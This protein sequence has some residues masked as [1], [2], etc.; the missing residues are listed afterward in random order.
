MNF[1]PKMFYQFMLQKCSIML[2]KCSIMPAYATM[3]FQRLLC[4]KLCQQNPPRPIHTTKINFHIWKLIQS[5]LQ[6]L[7]KL[8]YTLLRIYTS[9]GVFGPTIQTSHIIQYK[10][11][12]YKARPSD[13]PVSWI[14]Q[15]TASNCPLVASC[16]HL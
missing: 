3:L 9:A 11:M 16:C 14:T 2:Q 10:G 13:I 8:L 7:C 5:V 12:T 1:F 6:G 4:S 15:H